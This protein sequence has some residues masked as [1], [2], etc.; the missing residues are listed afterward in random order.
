[1][2]T[3]PVSL[4][5]NPYQS[6]EYLHQLLRKA[7]TA[8]ASDVHLKVGQPPGARVRGDIV[9]F[10]LD[11]LTAEG[12]FAVAAH[13]L[14]NRDPHVSLERLTNYDCSYEIPNLSRFRVNIYRQ[15]GTIAMVLRV[16]PY[17]IPTLEE[18]TLPSVCRLLAE[19]RNG[20]VLCVGAT[21]QGKS[22]TLSAMLDHLNHTVQRHIVTIEEPI[23]YVFEDDRCSV[24]QREIG[25]DTPS[26]GDALKGALRQDPD[27]IQIA[28]IRNRET[29]EQAIIAAETG[30]LVLST[31][32][33]PDVIRAVKR[34]FSLVEGGAVDDRTR[35]IDALKGII[36]QKLLPKTDGSG[37]VLATEILVATGNV[38]ES[39]KRPEGNPTLTELMEQ[40]AGLYGMHTFDMCIRQFVLDGIVN[41]DVARGYFGI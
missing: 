1:V 12:T 7:V 15:R 23:E 17:R 14:A 8:G 28:E 6:E 36:A 13:L 37:V 16:V 10:R 29:L 22:T 9:Y 26:V 41:S 27:V 5:P 18:L 19:Q 25:L 2:E 20:I 39:L 24:S 34:V 4:A 33:A 11:K 38:R 3:I 35:F 30:H 21:G 32:N 40:G 31:L